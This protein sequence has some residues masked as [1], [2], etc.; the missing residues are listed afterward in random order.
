MAAQIINAKKE[1]RSFLNEITIVYAAFVITLA[2]YIIDKIIS[3]RQIATLESL[4]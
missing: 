1:D 3:S 4:K 2:A